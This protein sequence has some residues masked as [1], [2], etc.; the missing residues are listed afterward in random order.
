MKENGVDWLDA[1]NE[2]AWYEEIKEPVE[3]SL[4]VKM[5][6]IEVG[7]SKDDVVYFRL[8]ED[9]EVG[10]LYYTRLLT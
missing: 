6:N 8:P 7:S 5:L 9:P 10:L 4:E 2:T 1:T 3:R